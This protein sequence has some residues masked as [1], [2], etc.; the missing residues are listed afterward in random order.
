[1][2]GRINVAT[3][4][5]LI[6]ALNATLKKKYETI[7]KPKKTIK[8]K[9]LDYYCDWKRDENTEPKGACNFIDVDY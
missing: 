2:R 5:K 1:M 3:V 8:P 9:E 4:N 6:D 7:R